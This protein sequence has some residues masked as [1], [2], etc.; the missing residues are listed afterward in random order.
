MGAD[1]YA[2]RPALTVNN[3]GEGKAYYIAS[4]NDHAFQQAFYQQLA[5]KLELKRAIAA[6]CQKI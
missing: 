6:H 4:R 5:D 1:F 2:G 3:F